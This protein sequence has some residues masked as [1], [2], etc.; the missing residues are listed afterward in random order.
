MDRNQK[1]APRRCAGYA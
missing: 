1:S